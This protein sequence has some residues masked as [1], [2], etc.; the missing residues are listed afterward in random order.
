MT[1]VAAVTLNARQNWV[2]SHIYSNISLSQVY[3]EKE[4]PFN[5]LCLS[6][7]VLGAMRVQL[8]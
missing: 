1:P 8:A 4:D 5:F 3:F 7:K 2:S 6:S